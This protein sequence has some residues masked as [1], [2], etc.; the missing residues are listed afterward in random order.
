MVVA[1][2]SVIRRHQI[3]MGFQFARANTVR[4][5]KGCAFFDARRVCR[6]ASSGENCQRCECNFARIF[7][8]TRRDRRRH[9]Q[10]FRGRRNAVL[11]KIDQNFQLQTFLEC[12]HRVFFDARRVSRYANGREKCAGCV[13]WK[14]YARATISPYSSFSF[15]MKSFTASTV[16]I[17]CEQAWD[18]T[19]IAADA[20]PNS[21]ASIMS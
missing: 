18:A 11:R 6:C 13:R 4:P 15:L 9:M 14:N 1:P 20:E 7:C 21:K 16:G 10:I 5:Y 17:S 3:C 12:V 2:Y 19:S 8:R